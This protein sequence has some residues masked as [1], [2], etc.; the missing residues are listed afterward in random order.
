MN[1]RSV[2]A[3]FVLL[4]IGAFLVRS[5]GAGIMC[6]DK[7][8]TALYKNLLRKDFGLFF[9]HY[10]PAK[11]YSIGRHTG[12]II[13]ECQAATAAIDRGKCY[14]SI[15]NVAPRHG[16]SDVVS[17]RFPVWYLGNHPDHEIILA[18]YSAE[19]AT[20]MSLA[21][22]RCMRETA[23]LFGVVPAKDRMRRNS[24]GLEDRKGTMNA[25][26]LG[27]SITGRGANVLVIDDYV[28][29]R[30]EAESETIRNKIWDSFRND[31]FTRLAPTH[32][33]II[34][35]TRWH[36]DD[37]V[38]RILSEGEN[39]PDFPQFKTVKYPAHDKNGNWLFPE[40]FDDARYARMKAAVGR[41]AWQALFMQDPAP[42]TGNLLRADLVRF[43][44]DSS[45]PSDLRLIRGWDIA[46]TEKER[47][48][49]DPD[50][51]VG[52]LAGWHAETRR[53]YVL[54][55]VRGRWSTLKRDRIIEEVAKRDAAMGCVTVNLEAVGGYIDTFNHISSI[56]RAY[57]S[58]YRITP[59]VDKVANAT[60]LEPI[61]ELGE[62]YAVR[63]EWNE[64]WVAEL[65]SFPS[66][67]HDDQV[68]SL[69]IA[70]KQAI[71]SGG[72]ICAAT[73]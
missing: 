52:T 54:D 53:L 70:S 23:P 66:G 63:G 30:A 18:S 55:V 15:I 27:G 29:N 9:T 48:K 8:K 61:F 62:V 12:G 51:T 73:V 35:A 58:I 33:V 56:L 17:R 39:N 19:L 31:L 32:A 25:V 1:D 2:F 57:A 42:R 11:N 47:T 40:R 49:N 67:K 5:G 20:D 7:E 34:V 46:S 38:G 50:Y 14:Y 41:Y 69:V 65:S 68:D 44:D 21:A 13:A 45:I 71:Q 26:G 3:F 43:I 37:L 28:K 36:E 10:A 4:L 22:R 64:D 16:K 6:P 59:T 60:V 24:W 72:G